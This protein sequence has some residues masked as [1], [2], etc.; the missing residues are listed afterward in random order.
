MNDIEVIKIDKKKILET[1]NYALEFTS[2]YQKYKDKAEREIE[3]LRVQLPFILAPIREDDLIAGHMEHTYLG[4]SPQHGGIYIYFFHDEWFERELDGVRNYLDA[5]SLKQVEEMASFWRSERTRTKLDHSFFQHFGTKHPYGYTE[6]GAT[7]ADG[8]IAGMVIDLDKLIRLG[9]PG[10]RKEILAKTVPGNTFFPALLAALDLMTDTMIHYE[11]EAKE[12]ADAA[13]GVRKKQLLDMAQALHNIQHDAPKT[14]LEG[15][16]LFWIYVVVSDLLN[17]GRMDV[18]LGDLYANDIDSGVLSEEEALAYLKSLY[19]LI[20]RIYKVFDQRIIIGGKGRRNEANADRLALAIMETSERI[21]DV[22]P[23]LTLRYYTGMNEEVYQKALELNMKGATF[24]IIYSDDTNIPA[25]TSVYDISLE[26]AQRYVPFGCGEYV[27]EGLSTGTPNCG[28]NCLKALELALFDG[29]D[30]IHQI[31]VGEKTGPGG[32]I[33]SWQTLWQRYEA[34]LLDGVYKVAWHNYHNYVEA[35]KAASLLYY[36]MLTDDCIEHGKAL[37]DGGVR[38]MN[39]AAEVFGIISAVDS[40]AAIK[41]VVFEDKAFTMHHLIKM[42]HADFE[43]YET[44]RKLLINAPKYGN[45]DDYADGMAI[46]V[47]NHI[48]QMARDAGQKVG[49]HKYDIVSVNNSMS[50]GWG[51]Y[52]MASADGR[53]KGTAMSNAN[54]PSIGADQ[55]GMT[56]LLN[57]MSKF[58]NSQHVGVINNIRFG[59]EMFEKNF[60]QI[61]TLVTT[62]FQNNGTQLNITVVGKDD[63]EQAILYPEK[64]QNLIVRIGGFS[65]RFVTLDEVIQREIIQRTTYV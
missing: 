36:S 4:F 56:A 45:D 42:L 65:A 55:R 20:L 40:F 37:L 19:R 44:E 13:V 43:G 10:L 23:Q 29:Y 12:L 35:N 18:Y 5:N 57:S 24:P 21:M 26:E 1:L 60:Q 47:F 53:K 59:R 52:C 49:F 33:D 14:F 34:Q 58:D 50:A 11:Q 51:E 61:K 9:V 28:I 27:L 16:Q 6:P 38:Y 15:I 41:K 32:E 2:V 22:I 7:N 17:Y 3:C 25:V 8:R 63:L 48:A 46:K 64:H 62:F 54:S 30:H 31:Q 39:A